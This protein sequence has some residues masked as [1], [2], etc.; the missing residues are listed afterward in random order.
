MY[1][2]SVITLSDRSY[3]KE[4]ADKSGPALVA[5]MEEHGFDV[6]H[7]VVLPDDETQLAEEL[8][9]CCDEASIDI[10]LTTGGTGL[11]PRDRTPEATEQVIH[12]RVPGISDYMRLKSM[13][14]TPRGM[15]SR[16]VAG[17]RHQ[18]LIIN[19]PGSPKAATEC[20]SFIIDVLPHALSTMKGQVTDCG[21][22][23]PKERN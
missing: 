12:R 11:A 14:I 21:T 22:S 7:T 20:I 15:L 16:G 17:I 5:Y 8:V 9:R 10:I 18:T 4:R 19:L 6:V 3:K 2:C 13:E 23:E 1:R